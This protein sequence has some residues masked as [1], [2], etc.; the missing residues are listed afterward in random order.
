VRRMRVLPARACS[1][2]S[3]SEFSSPPA[4]PSLTRGARRCEGLAVPQHVVVALCTTHR[5][6]PSILRAAPAGR[7]RVRADFG[8]RSHRSVSPTLL[9]PMYAPPLPPL[10]AV[11]VRCTTDGRRTSRRHPRTEPPCDAWTQRVR[12]CISPLISLIGSPCAPHTPPSSS[13]SVAARRTRQAT[14]AVHDEEATAHEDHRMPQP[15]TTRALGAPHLVNGREREMRSRCSFGTKPASRSERPSGHL[16]LSRRGEGRKDAASGDTGQRRTTLA[17]GREPDV[18][19]GAAAREASPGFR[20]PSASVST[21]ADEHTDRSRA[22]T[23]GCCG[24]RWRCEWSL[25]F[26]ESVLPHSSVV[27]I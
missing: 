27:A 2:N 17:S 23:G 19:N 3:S 9:F 4:W 24:G 5:R 20:D 21:V 7:Q 18:R 8:L 6:L 11:A 14:V 15:H 10:A 13:F 25:G 12:G 22:G 26:L 1:A 16:T